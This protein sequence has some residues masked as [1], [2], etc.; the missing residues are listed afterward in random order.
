MNDSPYNLPALGTTNNMGFNGGL[1]DFGPT[2]QS[3]NVKV[4]VNMIE[5]C[6]LM[7]EIINNKC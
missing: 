1:F 7:I 4:N 5:I 3:A 2:S 6:V